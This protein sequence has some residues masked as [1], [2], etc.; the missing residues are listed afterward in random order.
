MTSQPYPTVSL[1]QAAAMFAGRLITDFSMMRVGNGWVLL[2]LHVS[3]GTSVLRDD[4]PAASEPGKIFATA[5]DA[6]AVARQ[7]GFNVQAI[8]RWRPDGEKT[9]RLLARTLD[10]LARAVDIR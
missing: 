4:S 5:D 3:E 7:I 8:G 2:L 10:T 6:L 1:T 9:R